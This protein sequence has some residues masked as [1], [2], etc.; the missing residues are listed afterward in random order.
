MVGYQLTDDGSMLRF[1]QH[2]TPPLQCAR[3]LARTAGAL[4]P[5][6]DVHVRGDAHTLTL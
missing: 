5:T 2:R 3:V 6:G 4:L 1:A